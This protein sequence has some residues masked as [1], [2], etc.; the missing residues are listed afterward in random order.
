MNCPF[1]DSLE[2]K[3]KGRTGGLDW[4]NIR[5]VLQNYFSNFAYVHYFKL[6]DSCLTYLQ[7]FCKCRNQWSINEDAI[8]EKRRLG[9]FK[10]LKDFV[11]LKK[12]S[13]LICRLC[14]KESHTEDVIFIYVENQIYHPGYIKKILTLHANDIDLNI[15]E[16][17]VICQECFNVI[18]TFDALYQMCL[19]NQV[20]K[21][22]PDLIIKSSGDSRTENLH[23]TENIV[24]V[25]LEKSYNDSFV[26]RPVTEE[27]S[28]VNTLMKSKEL[29]TDNVV[30]N[31]CTTKNVLDIG[32][33]RK[34]QKQDNEN[35]DVCIISD[36]DELKR[37]IPE[38]VPEG[39]NP[40]SLKNIELMNATSANEDDLIPQNIILVS[41]HSKSGSTFKINSLKSDVIEIYD[42][43]EEL[44]FPKIVD[45][46]SLNE[47][48]ASQLQNNA[49]TEEESAVVAEIKSK[50]L[51]RDNVVLNGW[52]TKKVLD[53]VQHR[54]SQKQGN[55]KLDV[56][57]ISE[58]GDED[59]ATNPTIEI[60]MA[61]VSQLFEN[62]EGGILLDTIN[63]EKKTES[64]TDSV[65]M[66]FA[67]ESSNSTS[68]HYM[69]TQSKELLEENLSLF[70]Q[71]NSNNHT[72]TISN[73]LKRSNDSNDDIFEKVRLT[74]VNQV[75]NQ[76]SEHSP[77]KFSSAFEQFV[78]N[79]KQR[80]I[81][82]WKLLR[83]FIFNHIKE[84]EYCS[85]YPFVPLNRKSYPSIKKKF[86]I[87]VVE[88]RAGNRL[89]RCNICLH[90]M[91]HEFEANCHDCP[92]FK[93]K[94]TRAC[95]QPKCTFYTF[96]EF[97]FSQ[98]TKAHNLIPIESIQDFKCN[99]CEFFSSDG[100]CLTNHNKK[101]MKS[102]GKG[103]LKGS[104]PK[105][106]FCFFQSTNPDILAH[107]IVVR[108]TDQAPRK[109]KFTE[110]HFG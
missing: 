46:T 68:S 71:F 51:S 81:S 45:V 53:L 103:T 58:N 22:E 31:G 54:R 19:E 75:E 21:V 1:C 7:E 6:C 76:V 59:I 107:H 27:E 73:S 93:K 10:Q 89:Y 109:S 102:Y 94:K 98:H 57:N 61:V 43:D 29:S 64:D 40:R 2:Q 80:D 52:T 50:E 17:P 79:K 65:D 47:I 26:L 66:V 8:N 70:L 106:S 100:E 14:L 97:L 37:D 13:S 69:K 63:T 44:G 18:Q 92:K 62:N 85:W 77:I 110:T 39:N 78:I 30:L 108:H 25:Q 84:D 86:F 35:P 32:D 48:E 11:N 9:Q 5:K 87:T 3:K 34:S 88:N 104:V 36:E 15:T 4:E 20:E 67:D 99:F 105:C 28:A 24:H 74:T 41:K 23:V 91:N 55:E 83:G 16:N 60:N 90:I 56:C 72:N 101:H 95:P 82:P 49:I 42:S 96:N 12:E 38:E 33:H